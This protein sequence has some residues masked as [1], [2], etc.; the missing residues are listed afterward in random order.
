[1]GWGE[2]AI[3]SGVFVFV[4]G[5]TGRDS[6]GPRAGEHGRA[7][8]R[9]LGDHQGDPREGRH[10]VRQHRPADHVRDRHG[11]VVQPRRR[12]SERWL[13]KNA[14]ELLDNEPGSALIGVQRLALSAMKVEIMVIAVIPD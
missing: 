12:L 10:L 4:S 14:P 6:H 8:R 13:S 3:A 9:V 11:R 7:D 1:M 2:G 5:T